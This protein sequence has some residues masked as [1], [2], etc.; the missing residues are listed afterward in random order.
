[1]KLAEITAK[2]KLIKIVLNEEAIIEQ[3]GE[4]LEFYTWDRQPMEKYL[5]L[6]GNE[7]NAENMP[8]IIE[9][10]KTMILDERGEPVMTGDEILPS[11]VM[12][13]AINRVVTNLGKS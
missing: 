11:Y 13:L 5:G 4:E 6:V 12:S 8:A 9:F 1:M 2:P 7:M 3:Y 10:C